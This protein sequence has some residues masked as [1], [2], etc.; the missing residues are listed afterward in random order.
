MALSNRLDKYRD[1]E[2]WLNAALLNPNGGT[3]VLRTKN[4]A[5]Q[6]R[7]RAY[8][9]RKLY[10]EEMREAFLHGSD[11]QKM[12]AGKSPWDDFVLTVED[13]KVHIRR[14]TDEVL[15]FIPADGIM[16]EGPMNAT[17]ALDVL[18]GPAHPVTIITPGV[19]LAFGEEE[20]TMESAREIAQ[21]MAKDAGL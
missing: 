14:Q 8:Y 20:V 4:A 5:I 9:F 3:V 1:V 7:Q 12:M 10:A 16:P 6:W 19:P 15:E 17:E 11:A 2:Q 21:K 18:S 13:S